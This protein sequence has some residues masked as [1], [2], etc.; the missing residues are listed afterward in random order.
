[1]FA[2][3]SHL[4][5]PFYAWNPRRVRRVAADGATAAAREEKHIMFVVISGTNRPGNNTSKVANRVRRRLESAGHEVLLVDLE[6]LPPETF[7][8][9]SYGEKPAA[10][11]PIQEAV[12][13]AEGIIT[14]VPEYNGSFPGALKYF[15]DLLRF[16]ESLVGVPSAFIGLAAGRWGGLR[17]VEQ[18]EMVFQYRSAH[19]FGKRCFLPGIHALLDDS[20]EL[21]DGDEACRMDALV[22]EF[23]VFA[24][25]LKK[26]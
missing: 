26:G 5:T 15:I 13:V 3:H 9:A 10:I 23:A 7:T 8:P 6:A 25:A 17:A 2:T 1:V 12:L 14:V 20:G 4:R 22:D 21:A 19:L 11:A 16:P 18:L 24:A